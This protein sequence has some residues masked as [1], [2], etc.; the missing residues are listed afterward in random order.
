VSAAAGPSSYRW[1]GAAAWPIAAR[2]QQPGIPVIGFLNAASPDAFA[3]IVHAFRL[4][5]NETGY[6]EGQNVAVEYRWAENQYD[7]LPALA[8]ELVRRRV[9]VITTGSATLAALD[10]RICAGG[11]R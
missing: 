3:H 6:I 11:A 10:V 5:L 4:G 8:A 7:R 9:S 2:A 1:S